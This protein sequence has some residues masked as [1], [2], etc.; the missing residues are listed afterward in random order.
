MG[1]GPISYQ[2]TIEERP[3]YLHAKVVG[4]RTGANAL[5]FLQRAYAACV[6]SGHSCVLLEVHFSGPSLST[7]AI[8][9][10]I[11][12]RVPDARKLRKIAYVATGLNDPT[13]PYFAETVAVNRGV[14]VRLFP[15]VD[16]AEQWLAEEC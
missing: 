16:A 6:K 9:N 15:N 14:N 3:G 2:V 8:F 11:S 7:T 10:V 12:D 13:L 5:R 1:A 4:E